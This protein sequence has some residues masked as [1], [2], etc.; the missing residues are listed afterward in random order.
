MPAPTS[1]TSVCAAFG[2]DIAVQAIPPRSDP[3]EAGSA[4]DPD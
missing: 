4:A 1:T 2:S 3:H